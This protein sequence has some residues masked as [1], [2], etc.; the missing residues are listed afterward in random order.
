M[1]SAKKLA[2]LVNSREDKSR[3]VILRPVV[4]NTALHNG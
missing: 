1:T 3:N 4:L 2:H